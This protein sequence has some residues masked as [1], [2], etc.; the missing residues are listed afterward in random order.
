MSFTT[1]RSFPF[2]RLAIALNSALPSDV[3]V[4]ECRGGRRGFLRAIL[5]DASDATCLPSSTAAKRRRSSRTAPITYTASSISCR[6]CEGA[7]HLRRHA[8]LPSFC[9]MMPDNGN[10]VRTVTAARDRGARRFVAH[11]DGGRRILA[12]HGA[13]DRRHAGRMR[14][15]APRP[16]VAAGRPGARERGRRPAI[17][18]PRTASISPAS[19]T[20]DGYDSFA[21]PFLFAPPGTISPSSR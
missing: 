9:G 10:T 3:S 6:C 20:R 4:R 19:V 13:H 17:T 8:R 15:G 11:A 16:G 5:G 12:S 1:A 18:A 21:E 2:D 14:R 7:R